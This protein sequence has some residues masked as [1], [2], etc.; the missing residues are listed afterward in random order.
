MYSHIFLICP[1]ENIWKAKI[2]QGK[3]KAIE[4]KITSL[5]GKGRR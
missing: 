3:F 1:R 2:A 4:C 5:Q